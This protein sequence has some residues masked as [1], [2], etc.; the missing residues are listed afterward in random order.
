M[1]PVV[2]F[3]L[4]CLVG[5]F[6]GH[7]LRGMFL[8]GKKLDTSDLVKDL[9]E[10]A[11]DPIIII[12]RTGYIQTINPAGVEASGYSA[13]ELV[14]KHF[15]RAPVLAE[16][17]VPVAVREFARVLWGGVS[18]PHELTIVRKDGTTRVY[19]VR[20]RGVRENGNVQRVLVMFRDVTGRKDLESALRARVEELRTI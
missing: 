1:N 5:R 7:F 17:S 16:V 3:V 10:I 11:P 18:A 2:I 20:N 12:D 13:D 4:G 8:F 14:G 19:E 9:A 15:S 6:A